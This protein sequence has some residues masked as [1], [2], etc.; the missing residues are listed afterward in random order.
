MEKFIDLL[1]QN[2]IKEAAN[3]YSD[4]YDYYV[5]PLKKPFR[6]KL[7][8]TGKRLFY[9]RFIFKIL[10][11][12]DY[13]YQG[14]FLKMY[15]LDRYISSLNA[16]YD[17]LE[18]KNSKDLLLKIVSFRILGYIKV[19]LP[20]ST[21]AYWEGIK[22]I[23]RL[24]NPNDF[25]ELPYSPWKLNMHDLHSINIPLKAYLNAKGIY[26][27]FCVDQYKYKSNGIC[28]EALDG[29]DVF[30]LGACY[31]D[32]ALYFAQKVGINGKVYSFEFIPG[33]I[34]VL[35]KNIY[36]NQNLKSRI[37]IIDRPVWNKSGLDVFYKDKG[38][39]SSI[40]F[41]EFEGATGR[42][43]TVSIDDF[44]EENNLSKVD[45][46]KTDIEGAEPNAL[47][48]AEK[49]I[50]KFKPRLAISIYHNISDFT[51]IIK[52]IDDLKLGYKFYLGHAT[53]FTS[54]TVLF[55]KP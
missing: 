31:G 13:I 10:F 54:E 26:T 45:F 11:R 15:H 39:S 48:G 6:K 8:N 23:E 37:K 38:A 12:S 33:N 9:Q 46:I 49:T 47:I 40:D 55:C 24:E 44:V 5:H 34:N 50:K 20:L 27:T 3:Y 30:D 52:Q 41:K 14:I 42:T 53:I 18:D 21:P 51:G 17:L 25:L 32:T 36:S 16:F 22:E 1:K 7:I 2:L 43:T 35:N 28:V 29:D 4:N 19:R